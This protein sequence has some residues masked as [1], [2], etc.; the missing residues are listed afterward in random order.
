[1]DDS[2]DAALRKHQWNVTLPGDAVPGTVRIASHRI[3]L[4]AFLSPAAQL[5]EAVGALLREPCGCFEQTSSTTYPMIL[6][7]AARRG[8]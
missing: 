1:V 6:A 8:R 4:R 3:A 5:T 7:R 2:A